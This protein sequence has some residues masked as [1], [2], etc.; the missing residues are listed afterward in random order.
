MW[1]RTIEWV[2]IIPT[3]IFLLLQLSDF[4]L[5]PRQQKIHLHQW[6][7]FFSVYQWDNERCRMLLIPRE[8]AIRLSRILHE[9]VSYHSDALCAGYA[10]Y[11][12]QMQNQL[13]GANAN[14]VEVPS[15]WRKPSSVPANSITR[16]TAASALKI[17]ITRSSD[18][19]H[20]P[21]TNP[22]CR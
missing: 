8:F 11:V 3:G 7:C 2:E 18:N 4:H 20:F 19:S 14:E 17:V 10:R 22:S 16:Q 5:V 12:N 6:R 1:L 21:L 15:Y 9:D 13:Y